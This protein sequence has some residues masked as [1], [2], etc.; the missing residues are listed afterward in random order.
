MIITNSCDNEPLATQTNTFERYINA[1]G[2]DNADR[3][4]P[5]LRLLMMGL[6]RGPLGLCYGGRICM[7]MALD[8]WIGVSVGGRAAES[9]EF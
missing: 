7:E 2:E 6:L 4:R 1:G 8:R 3:S 9:V 5:A